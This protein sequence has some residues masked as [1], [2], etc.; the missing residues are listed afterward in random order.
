MY[1]S[2]GTLEVYL[3]NRW[4]TVCYYGFT[5]SAAN[6]ACHQ[7][8]YTNYLNLNFV[9]DSWVL[10][11]LVLHVQCCMSLDCNQLLG[12]INIQLAV[13]NHCTGVLIL[14][15]ISN[16]THSPLVYNHWTGLVDWTGELTFFVLNSLL[17]SLMRPHS[18]VGL[19]M[20]WYSLVAWCTYP[21]N[22]IYKPGHTVLSV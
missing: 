15:F 20:N 1:H 10:Q 2:S 4:G 3:N 6:T 13:Y 18:P 5:T 7:L 14:K 22:E 21:R 9:T 8:G 16:D 17:C 19:D 11:C 12:Y